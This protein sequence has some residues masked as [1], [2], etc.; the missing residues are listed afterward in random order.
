MLRWVVLASCASR[1]ARRHH[2]A[3]ACGCTYICVRNVAPKHRGRTILSAKDG[4]VLKHGA[5]TKH[6]HTLALGRKM[7]YVGWQ[8][9]GSPTRHTSNGGA[10]RLRIPLADRA[11]ADTLDRRAVFVEANPGHTLTGR[12][13]AP[14]MRLSHDADNFR[15]GWAWKAER[16]ARDSCR[17]I[18]QSSCVRALRSTARNALMAAATAEDHLVEP[19]GLLLVGF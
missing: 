10:P 18:P 16:A 17:L 9:N 5:P 2:A 4:K 6:H 8:R 14:T 11:C 3:I 13:Q 12:G 7:C 15:A 19:G 1:K